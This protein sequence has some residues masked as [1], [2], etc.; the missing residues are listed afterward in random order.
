MFKAGDTAVVAKAAAELKVGNRVVASVPQGT[1][2]KVLAVQGTW[3]GASVEQK[4]QKFSGWIANADLGNSPA[5]A[6]P[7]RR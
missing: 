4:G 2:F 7:V 6:P 5:A 3:I 1:Q